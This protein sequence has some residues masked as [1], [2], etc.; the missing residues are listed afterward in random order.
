MVIF[1]FVLQCF[2]FTIVFTS[3]APVSFV[4]LKSRNLIV[5]KYCLA[6]IKKL[7]TNSIHLTE[8]N[9]T[10]GNAFDRLCGCSLMEMLLLH[11]PSMSITC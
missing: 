9:R 8:S 7:S 2:R 1:V 6:E 4:F 3:N 5:A 10:L 11:C